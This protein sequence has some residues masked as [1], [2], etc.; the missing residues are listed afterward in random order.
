MSLVTIA[1]MRPVSREL[2]ECGVQ[3]ARIADC[4]ELWLA[5]NGIRAQK[6]APDTSGDEPEAF[7]TNDLQDA[8]RELEDIRKGRGE[9]E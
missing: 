3:L 7:Y 2:H 6:R 8:L 5:E 1:R 4:L 9:P